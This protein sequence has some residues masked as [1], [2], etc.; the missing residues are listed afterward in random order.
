MDVPEDV[1]RRS[2]SVPIRLA[3]MGRAKHWTQ[4][5]RPIGRW[6]RYEG[7]TNPVHISFTFSGRS[8]NSSVG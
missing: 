5:S 2:T 8:S 6:N 3:M 4:W 1:E 7:F